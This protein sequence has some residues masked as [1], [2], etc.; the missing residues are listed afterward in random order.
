MKNIS[1]LLH[2]DSRFERECAERNKVFTFHLFRDIID[3]KILRSRDM[4]KSKRTQNIWNKIPF[5]AIGF[6]AILFVMLLL[7]G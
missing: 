3:Y 4:Q 7:C 1:A 2:F 5:A 6:V